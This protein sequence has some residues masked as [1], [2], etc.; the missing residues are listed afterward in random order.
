[1]ARIRVSWDPVTNA[2]FY[3]IYRST[4]PKG[5]AFV[6]IGSN[7]TDGTSFDDTNTAAF[8]SYY[9]KVSYTDIQSNESAFSSADAGFCQAW[10]DPP[11]DSLSVAAGGSRD[12]VVL[13]WASGSNTS[14]VVYTI[15]RS[16]SSNGPFLAVSNTAGTSAELNSVPSGQTIWFRVIA[17]DIAGNASL[18]SDPVSFSIPPVTGVAP[19]PFLTA[20]TGTGV[21]AVSLSWGISSDASF[22]RVYRST[23]SNGAF[24]LLRDNE[25]RTAWSDNSAEEGK[26][27]YYRLT[28][29]SG[30]GR[31]SLPSPL[32]AGWKA[33]STWTKT[34]LPTASDGTTP[35]GVHI[36][37]LEVDGAAG[38]AVYRAASSGGN[39]ILQAD[40]LDGTSWL[41]T[42]A[43]AGVTYY[44]KIVCIRSS[45]ERGPQGPYDAGFRA[46]TGGPP[47]PT[48]VAGG[49]GVLNKARVSWDDMGSS[50]TYRVYGADNWHGPWQEMYA[51]G[52]T[53]YTDWGLEYG[54]YYRVACRDSG[55]RIGPWSDPVEPCAWSTVSGPQGLTA[56]KGIHQGQIL[57]SWDAPYSA[58]A[59]QLHRSDSPTGPFTR[60]GGNLDDS[61]TTYTD[62]VQKGRRYYKIRAHNLL[63]TAAFGQVVMGYPSPYPVLPPPDN[64]RAN[65]QNSGSEVRLTWSSVGNASG[66]IIYRSPSDS[67]MYGQLSGVIRGTEYTDSG[68]ESNSTWFYKILSVNQAGVQGQLSHALNNI[69]ALDAPATVMA[70]DGTQVNMVTILWTPVATADHYK[71][72]RSQSRDGI[73]VNI[74]DPVPAGTTMFN[75]RVPLPG[76]GY[77][78]VAAYDA[79]EVQGGFSA[80]D[81]GSPRAIPVPNPPASMS[82]SDGG[83]TNGVYLS[84]DIAADAAYYKVA[85]SDREDGDYV[86]ISPTVSNTTWA[87]TGAGGVQYFYK[88]AA[89]N[90]QGLSGR[91]SSYDSGHRQ[92]TDEEFL[93]VFDTTLARSHEKMTLMHRAGT[94]ALGK[95]VKNGDISGQV[96]YNAHTSGLGAEIFFDYA[97]YRDFYLVLN[98]R[99]T[100]RVNTSANGTMTGRIEISSPVYS[101]YVRYDLKITSG[102]AAGGYWYVSQNNAPETQIAWF[103]SP[104]SK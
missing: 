39:Y 103:P 30:S 69:T 13:T 28:A 32:A 62:S 65:N 3:N 59:I 11:P 70:S 22:Y 4:L 56:S 43:T 50:F 25:I 20:T 9:Y 23:S 52:S 10:R 96:A 60:I 17:K 95:E 18:I 5:G 27:Y 14:A 58:T 81:A 72:F 76:T 66:Y 51:G 35:S 54:R 36:S 44:Y 12:S 63:Y 38:Y 102:N 99:Y 91:L 64:Y 33:L 53:T 45:G 97:R 71:I 90:D 85:R 49:L 73:Y 37:W 7:L 75:D 78:K 55:R 74:G 57:L 104:S 46:H 47:M 77:Y 89:F 88:I 100:I 67:G 19:P 1:M 82:A 42:N 92:L 86:F 2:R 101:G 34:T 61:A 6:L 79:A 68:L 40:D 48:G 87:D 26:T 24:N 98:G 8:F 21:T 93:I 83:S 29:V 94:G 31:E 41:D 80:S 84:W 16:T 15:Y